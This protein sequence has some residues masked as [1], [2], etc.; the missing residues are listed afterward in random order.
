[1]CGIAGFV[2]LSRASSAEQLAATAGAM[3]H[4]L[5]HRGPDD[6]GVWVDEAVGV[7]FGHR[8]L[9]IIDLS[10]EGHQPMVSADG[11]WVVAFNGEIYNF[12]RLRPELE[13]RGRAFRGHSDTEVLLAAVSEWGVDGAVERCNG[14][15]AIALWDRFERRLWLA[16]DRMG[17]KPLF[18]GYAGGAFLFASELKALRQHP[19]FEPA[20]D[21]DALALF[22][23]Y[24]Y[25]PA[26]R[27]IYTGISKLAPGCLLSVRPGDAEP[28]VRQYWSLREVAERAVGERAAPGDM[29]DE[30]EDVLSDA[31]G[32]RMT[33][34]VPLGA[35]LSGGVDSSTVVALM[36]A[37]A[38]R[39]VRTFTIGFRE[40][41]Y[42][43][44][45]YARE[46]ARHLGT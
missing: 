4:C 34:D 43:E 38:S 37:Q 19:G 1:M 11:R 44:A 31:V 30:L 25:V 20:V 16:R 10:P 15:F 23:R 39:P 42:D 26:P 35:L 41:G 9:A 7:A 45:G 32:L 14:M 3:A 27:S 6:Q 29:I 46:V 2:D 13:R 22:F 24:G 21:R 8:R 5:V 36:Q 40:A 17:E 33:A 18:Y 28:T 12:T